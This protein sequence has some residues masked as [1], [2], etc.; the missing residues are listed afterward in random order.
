MYHGERFNGITH[1]FGTLFAI[2]A[3]AA[4][5]LEASLQGDA[6]K[7]F[8]FSLYGGS[9][10]LLYLVSTLYHSA[11]GRAKAILQKC[12]HSA[13]YLLIAGS[14]TPFSLITLRGPWG[15]TLFFLSW[16]LAIFGIVQELTLGKRTRLLSMI[17]YVV[18]GWLILIAIKP[19]MAALPAA[20]L[21]W[22]ALGGVFYSVGIYWFLNDEKIRHGHGIW[23]LFVLAGS[24]CQF[25]SVM[26]Y[27]A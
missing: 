23:H 4:L 10:V 18:M 17:L 9:L 19:L 22:L 24:A 21:F 13:I 5:L 26:F 16:G 14:Y 2:T 3:L 8:S 11:R 12:D 20:G 6:W 7:L 1:L 25:V 15:W 27:V